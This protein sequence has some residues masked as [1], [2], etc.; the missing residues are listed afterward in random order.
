MLILQTALDIFGSSKA[1]KTDKNADE[2]FQVKFITPA[3][4]GVNYVLILYMYLK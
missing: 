4:E 1:D 2:P 3:W